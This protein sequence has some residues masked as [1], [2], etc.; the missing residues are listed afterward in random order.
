MIISN[1]LSSSSDKIPSLGP[2]SY[3]ARDGTVSRMQSLCIVILDEDYWIKMNYQFLFSFLP[4][5]SSYPAVISIWI[6]EANQNGSNLCA[7]NS[8]WTAYLINC[9]CCTKELGVGL[10]AKKVQYLLH[11]LIQIKKNAAR[12]IC[13]MK[14]TLNITIWKDCVEHLCEMV[15]SF[16][17]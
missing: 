14:I 12:S 13:Y 2:G 17:R 10:V 3:I 11:A 1:S 9:T 7:L 6:R 15:G 16:L 8:S 5:S 4:C